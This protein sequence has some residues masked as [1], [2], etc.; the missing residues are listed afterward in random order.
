MNIKLCGNIS[1]TLGKMD[2]HDLKPSFTKQDGF[3]MQDS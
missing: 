2:I 3:D 1:D